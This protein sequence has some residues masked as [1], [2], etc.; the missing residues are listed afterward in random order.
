SGVLS[1]SGG[2]DEMLSPQTSSQE[3]F[4]FPK[5]RQDGERG[6]S[7]SLPQNQSSKGRG[8]NEKDRLKKQ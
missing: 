2:V 1:G 8:E 3:V 6:D 4:D 5:I 7:R